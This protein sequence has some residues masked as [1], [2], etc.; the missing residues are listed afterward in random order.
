MAY[1]RDYKVTASLQDAYKLYKDLYN[2]IKD[3]N[4]YL[5]IAYEINKVIADM[6]ITQSLEYRLPERMGFL[7]IKKNKQK[8]VI[9][10]GRISPKKNVIDWEN[11]WKVWKE[12]YPDKTWKEIK[13]LKGKKVL[14]QTNPHTDGEIMKWYWRKG[15]GVKNS[16]VY[17]FNV[18][19][20]GKVDEYYTG[21]L[22]LAWWIKSDDK[23]ND[24][25][26]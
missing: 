13:K 22:G 20:G 16:T 19:K 9:V 8:L 12:M 25:Y 15:G 14:F 5:A 17:V 23:T 10:N 11:T 2:N 26:F 24:Y 4:E 18:V 1:E 7:R 3:K 21:R 6:I